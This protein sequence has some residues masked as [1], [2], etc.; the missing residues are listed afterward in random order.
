MTDRFAFAVDAP[1]EVFPGRPFKGPDGQSYAANW[2]TGASPEALAERLL[3]RIVET[4]VP[5]GKI[6]LGKSLQTVNGVVTEVHTLGAIPLVERK[7]VLLRAID[8]E[9]D[10]RQQLDFVQDFGELEAVNDALQTIAAGTRQLQMRFDRDQLNWQAL[11]S[12]A[13]LATV[14]GH[15]DAV[16][17]MRAEDNWNI[18]TQASDV[19]NVTTAMFARNAQILFFAAGLKTQV[20]AA[21]T[22][23]ALDALNILVGWPA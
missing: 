19:L 2:L 15:G 10:R 17:P 6:S 20:R 13:L 16:L 18:Q 1:Y 3:T 5:A 23:A 21:S 11:Q 9:R 12:Q 22:G 8:A 7:A 14:A 4:P